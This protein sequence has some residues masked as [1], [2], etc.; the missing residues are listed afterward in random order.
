MVVFD[1][2]FNKTSVGLPLKSL[3]G[4]IFRAVVAV[5][6]ILYKVLSIFTQYIL[7]F[8]SVLFRILCSEDWMKRES[9]ESP[10]QS[11]CCEFHIGRIITNATVLC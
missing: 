10:E 2:L 3:L 4:S 5:F 7:I 1:F 6:S 8:A 11:R 9:G